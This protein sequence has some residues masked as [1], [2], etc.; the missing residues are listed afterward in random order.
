MT[1]AGEGL[2]GRPSGRPSGSAGRV[3]VVVVLAALLAGALALARRTP[4][5]TSAR[6]PAGSA[7]GPAVAGAGAVSA[8]WYC[9]AGSLT[10]G[11]PAD[12]TVYVGNLAPAPVRAVVTAY[13]GGTEEPPTRRLDLDPYER[14]AVRV[15][16]LAAGG[17]PGVLVEVFGGPAVVEHEL[18]HGGDL[19]MGP[20]ARTPAR[21]WYFAAGDTQRGST[22]TLSLFNPFADDAIVDLRFVTDGGVQE[23][24]ALQ[25]LVVGRRSAVQ[26]AVHD[27]VPRQERVATRVHVR[28]GRVVA[29]QTRTFDGTDARAGATA[30][31]G[32]AGAR[33]TWTVPM[34][35]AGPGASGGVAIANFST[36]PATVEVSVLLSGEGVLEPET[37]DVPSRSV[38]VVDPSLRVP[39]GVAYAVIARSRGAAPI[40]V[41][42]VVAARTGTASPGAATAL[43]AVTGARRVALAGSPRGTSAAVVIANPG[44]AP[45]TAELRAHVPRDPDSPRSAPAIV[46]GPGR[47]GWFDLDEWG[48]R[49]EQ[50]LVVGADAPVVVAREVLVG[51]VSLAVGVPFPRR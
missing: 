9:A 48:I 18:R 8:A 33:P 6:V 14:A 7:G 23:P 1:G 10:A 39:A 15:A 25:G 5:V 46:I 38:V 42:A 36:A 16:D 50:V 19:A 4:E 24:Q 40:V 32:A 43:A 51:G 28:S 13:P 3:V 35:I 17:A 12:A 37:V 27:A 41:E 2:G 20:C 22:L 47:V 34:G 29:E 11:G 26:V 30:T 21:S 31:L 44:T 45:V 49:P